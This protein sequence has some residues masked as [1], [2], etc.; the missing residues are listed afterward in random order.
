MLNRLKPGLQRKIRR[1]NLPLRAPSETV[2]EPGHVVTWNWHTLNQ[3]RREAPEREP[4]E[5]GPTSQ[6]GYPF[7][8]GLSI[9]NPF[10]KGRLC[11]LK[12]IL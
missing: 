4:E 6:V 8:G 10:D 3:A 9:S 2:L 5:L 1:G 12:Y 7:Q 11:K